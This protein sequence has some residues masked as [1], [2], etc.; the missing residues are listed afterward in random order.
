MSENDASSI[1]IDNSSVTLQILVSLTDDSRGVIHDHN[2]FTVQATDGQAYSRL[3]LRT[4][5]ALVNDLYWGGIHNTS[6][7]L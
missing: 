5:L 1:V 7:S 3:K 4:S 2:M 6:F